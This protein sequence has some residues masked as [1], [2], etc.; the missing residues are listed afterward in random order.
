MNPL[1]DDFCSAV[2]ASAHTAHSA[3]FT[4]TLQGIPSSAYSVQAWRYA[5]ALD[6]PYTLTLVLQ[7]LREHAALFGSDL[8]QRLSRPNGLPA[9]FALQAQAMSQVPLYGSVAQVQLGVDVLAAEGRHAPL[10]P[11]VIACSLTVRP[12]LWW[13]GL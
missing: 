2:G 8:Q 11:E 12:R 6:E 13:A 10:G 1:N 4:L 5:A 3:P 7:V 9:C